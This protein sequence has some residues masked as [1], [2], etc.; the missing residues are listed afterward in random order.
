[1]IN[2]ILNYIKARL[3]ASH[4]QLELSDEAIID[5]LQQ[6]TLLTLSAYFPYY[7]EYNIE[8]KRLDGSKNIVLLPETLGGQY[9]V[10]GVQS[11]YNTYSSVIGITNIYGSNI[12]DS[13]S[14]FLDSKVNASLNSAFS[15]PDTFE[16]LPPNMLRLNNFANYSMNNTLTL[17]FKT[18]HRN[19]FATFPFGLRE[20]IKK[21]ALYDVS[22]DIYGIR[23]YFSNLSTT[24]AEIELNL[25]DLNVSDK[26]DELVEL[27]RRN[28]LKTSSAKKIWIV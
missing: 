12:D 3:G 15:N 4:R 20:T 23:K 24:F 19:D 16:F 18:T 7:I 13:I 10:I 9:R 8:L 6:E 25:D 26:R 14:S 28:Q 11:I 21:L 17:L 2:E 1:M 22:L 27:M 5:C